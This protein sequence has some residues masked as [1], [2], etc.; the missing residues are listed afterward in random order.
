MSHNCHEGKVRSYILNTLEKLKRS[1][2]LKSALYCFG[3]GAFS[4]KSST[5]GR[6]TYINGFSSPAQNVIGFLGIIFSCGA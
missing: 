2:V 4:P 6:E 3:Y 5:Y 1:I